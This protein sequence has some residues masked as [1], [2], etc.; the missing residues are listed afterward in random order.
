M[1]NSDCTYPPVDLTNCDREPIHI[2]GSI[3]P[4]GVLLALT[5]ADL[6]IVQASRNS[7]ELLGIAHDDLIGTDLPSILDAAAMTTLSRALADGSFRNV[8]GLPV[9]IGARTLDAILHRSEGLLIVELEEPDAHAPGTACDGARANPP[10]ELIARARDALGRLQ[11]ARKLAALWPTLANVVRD[12]T[13]FDRVMVYRFSER[14]RSG[15]VIAEDRRDDLEPYLGLHYPASDI[16]QQARRLYLLNRL[17][18]IPDATYAPVPIAPEHNPHTGRRLDLSHA[19][20]RSVSPIHCEYLANMGVRASMSISLVKDERLWGLIACHHQSPRRLSYR[21]RA[22]CELLGDICSW[23]LGP[24]I[25]NEE[26]RLRAYTSAVQRHLVEAVSVQPDLPLA[27]TTSV[28]SPLDM[29]DASGF[30]AAHDGKL[31]VLGNTPSREQMGEL[32]RW[33]TATMDGPAYATDALPAAYPPAH[34]FKDDVCG[35]LAAAVSKAQGLFLMW[36]RPE[37]VHEVSWGGDPRKPVEVEGERLTP[38]K[39]FAM[40]KETVRLRARPWAA[41]EIDAATEMRNLTATLVLRQAAEIFRLNIGLSEA[42]HSRDE[43]MSMASHELKTPMQTLSLQLEALELA[44]AANQLMPVQ[45]G[46]R[47]TVARRQVARL[48]R[49][50]SQLL[51]VSR[52]SAGRLDLDRSEVDL[53]A[54]AREVAGRF[55]DAG[56]PIHLDTGGD[57]TGWWDEFRLD[58]VLTNLVSNAIKYGRGQPVDITLRDQGATVRCLVRDRGMGI[59]FEE[60][61]RLF[62]RFD[63]AVP[64]HF[65]GF[66]L[67]LWITRQIIEQHGG[68]IEVESSPD[69]GATFTFTL[70]RAAG[71]SST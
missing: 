23:M 55:E 52:I 38:R 51:D 10:S 59:A 69:R 4:H 70:P 29:I 1:T 21:L 61:A 11:S 25:E 8:N 35:L 56:V 57:T 17:R 58:Q 63:R 48:D 60:Q 36:F 6:V 45:L 16:P 24:R 40:W 15:E 49:L 14:D 42:L 37:R 18:L 71:E 44:A 20:L 34:E 62:E 5:E 54:L 30:A 68:T 28:P 46:R 27:L 2:P 47:L 7:E 31:A 53:G 32:V 12:I 64:A 19:V 9:T 33:L 39:S 26:N 43:F 67:G 50:V 65:A 66:G 22:L 41:W 13:G 3:Q